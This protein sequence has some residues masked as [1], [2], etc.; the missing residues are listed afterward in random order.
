[1][2]S[3]GSSLFVCATEKPMGKDFS[4]WVIRPIS[5]V[6]SLWH[7]PVYYFR[8]GASVWHK[9]KAGDR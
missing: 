6:C 1:M 9:L 2:S 8:R 7:L 4:I 3:G 5:L